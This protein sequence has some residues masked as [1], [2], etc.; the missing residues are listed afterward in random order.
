MAANRTHK[1]RERERSRNENYAEPEH[2]MNREEG[3]DEGFAY[4]S[5]IRDFTYENPGTAVLVALGAGLGIGLLIGISVG[6][7]QSR[8]KSLRERLL[9]EGLGRRL[10]EHAEGWLPDVVAD[11][12]NR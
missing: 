8:P 6:M 10:L 11:R 1:Q 4:V 3:E 5:Q 2:S 12:L 7:P 9:A